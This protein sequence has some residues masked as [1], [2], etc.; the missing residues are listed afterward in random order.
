MSWIAVARPFVPLR[1][2]PEYRELLDAMR[3]EPR[4]GRKEKG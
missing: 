2:R 3:L 4:D 1:S